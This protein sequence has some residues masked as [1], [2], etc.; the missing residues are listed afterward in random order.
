MADCRITHIRKPDRFSRHE[1]IT[2][3]GNLVTAS[4]IWP[5]EN[6]IDS[7]ARGINTFFVLDPNSGKRSE[8]GVMRPQD[9]RS[10]YLQTHADGRWNDNLLSLPQC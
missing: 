9:G 5:R 7:I 3:V 10:P 1:H 6:I 4:W 2:H 8:V